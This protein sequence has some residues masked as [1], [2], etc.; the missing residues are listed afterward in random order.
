V[1]SLLPHEIRIGDVDI[2]RRRRTF[3][4]VP[5]HVLVTSLCIFG[6]LENTL[7]KLS[8]GFGDLQSSITR[9]ASSI[10]VSVS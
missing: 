8:A 4:S 7:I 9:R 3:P 1:I 5:E 2:R 10:S 6:E